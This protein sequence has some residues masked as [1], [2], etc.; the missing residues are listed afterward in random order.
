MTL[1][2]VIT[3]GCATSRHEGGGERAFLRHG[4]VPV[5]HS[6]LEGIR[7]AALVSEHALAVGANLDARDDDS[8]NAQIVT[9]NERPAMLFYLPI[10]LTALATTLYHIA[11]KSI[12]PGVH[13]LFSFTT[14]F[15]TTASL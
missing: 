5:R 2:G 15:R 7:H 13:P 11:Q 10:A 12:A 8:G 1:F 3:V 14:I 4:G 9:Y 6:L